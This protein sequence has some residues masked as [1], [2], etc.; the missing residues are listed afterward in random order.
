MSNHQASEGAADGGA[1]RRA[2]R[3]GAG[4]S[5]SPD[6]VP[7]TSS[8][9]N[10]VTEK[11]KFKWEDIGLT[12][13]LEIRAIAGGL[14]ITALVIPFSAKKHNMRVSPQRLRLWRGRCLGGK[15]HADGGGGGRHVL[16]LQYIYK[17]VLCLTPAGRCT[18]W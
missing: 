11:G 2:R 16:A 17:K 15:K 13:L 3:R 4:G 18:R 10:I 6:A 5:L 1:D 14:K 12:G 7:F 9:S 8:Q